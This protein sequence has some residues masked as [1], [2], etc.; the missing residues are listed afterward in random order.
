MR[1]CKENVVAPPFADRISELASGNRAL[2][3]GVAEP[4]LGC[5]LKKHYN[6]GAPSTESTAACLAP[7]QSWKAQNCVHPSTQTLKRNPSREYCFSDMHLF[8]H[9]AAHAG[10]GLPARAVDKAPSGEWNF[11]S[12]GAHKHTGTVLNASNA[13]DRDPHT[14]THTHTPVDARIHSRVTFHLAH[15]FALKG[16]DLVKA[17]LNRLDDVVR[18]RVSTDLHRRRRCLK[19]SLLCNVCHRGRKAR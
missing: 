10:S 11:D 4:Q 12:K 16:S 14:R 3:T 6:N 15:S 9:C 1:K 2:L 18:R 13:K 7:Q 5:P 8:S 17:R 19:H